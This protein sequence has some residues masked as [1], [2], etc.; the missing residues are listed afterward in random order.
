M[1]KE[2]KI[3]KLERERERGKP[4][5]AET[6]TKDEH[7]TVNGSRH[8]KCSWAWTHLSIMPIPSALW[9]KP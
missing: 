9:T 7:V 6:P 8:M 3:E 2:Q 1:T 4:F 5:A